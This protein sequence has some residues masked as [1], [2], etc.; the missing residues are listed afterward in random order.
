VRSRNRKSSK[1][2][3]AE[4]RVMANGENPALLSLSG[5][6][7]RLSR[8]VERARDGW[9]STRERE[10]ECSSFARY[11]REK[12][13]STFHA[14]NGLLKRVSDTRASRVGTPTVSH[15]RGLSRGTPPPP[16]P[17][18][19]SKVLADGGAESFLSG[20]KSAQFRKLK[21]I[22]RFAKRRQLQNTSTTTSDFLTR[23][24]L[25]EEDGGAILRP[26][27]RLSRGELRPG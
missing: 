7:L 3:S 1:G 20:G 24:F 17:P 15:R 26:P 4:K 8:V 13:D 6:R 5:P 14:Q 21:A 22:K 11:Y 16:P 25:P 27:R 2:S 10:R 23:E 12:Y 18:E 19:S 9:S